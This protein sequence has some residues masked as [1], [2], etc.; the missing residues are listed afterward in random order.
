VYQTLL[1][2]ASFFEFLRYRVRD[3]VGI[4]I[5]LFTR[6]GALRPPGRGCGRPSYINT[7]RPRYVRPRAAS[8]QSTGQTIRRAGPTRAGPD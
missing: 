2:D 6:G 7:A 5:L 3:L 8:R 4:D 1:A